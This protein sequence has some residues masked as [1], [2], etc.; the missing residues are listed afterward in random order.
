MMMTQDM[1]E[2]I[3]LLEQPMSAS[4]IVTQHQMA[5][6]HTPYH[7]H[8]KYEALKQSHDRLV[9]DFARI[10]RMKVFPDNETNMMT[11]SAIK[12]MAADRLAEAEKVIGK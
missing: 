8:D 4:M 10:T 7:R 1:P 11:L 12:H 5:K 9:A 2:T 3:Y 6:N